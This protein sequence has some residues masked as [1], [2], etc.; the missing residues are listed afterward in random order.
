MAIFMTLA[1]ILS[2]N[3]QILDL[4]YIFCF[5]NTKFC[6]SPEKYFWEGGHPASHL[7]WHEL[8]S[9]HEPC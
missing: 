4:K 7:Q 3:N 1:L 5:F 9:V 2:L 8:C 6:F